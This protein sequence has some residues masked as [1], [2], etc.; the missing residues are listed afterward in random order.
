MD[1]KK[2]A[3]RAARIS[4]YQRKRYAEL[5]TAGVCVRCLLTHAR[6]TLTCAACSDERRQQNQNQLVDC[7]CTV[8]N[9]EFVCQ[10]ATVRRGGGKFCSRACANRGPRKRYRTADPVA[11]FWSKVD[12]DGPT[13]SHRPE[14]GQCWVWTGTSLRFGYGSFYLQGHGRVSAHRASF[15][16]ARG[17]WPDPCCLHACDRPSCVRPSHLFEGTMADNVADMMQKRRFSV[18]NKAIGERHHNTKLTVADVVAIRAAAGGGETH[19]SIASRFGVT[20]AC[21]SHIVRRIV[22]RHVA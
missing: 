3:D 15:L 1:E 12:K 9:S 13:P 6:G 17:R 4:R 5:K 18:A 10:G 22:W 14:L 8:C 20:R 2:I 19:R 11:R 21:I 16:F 7:K